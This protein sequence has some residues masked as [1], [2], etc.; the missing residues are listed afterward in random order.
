MAMHATVSR[1]PSGALPDSGPPL[2]VVSAAE[3]IAPAELYMR[4]VTAPFE[5]AA[6]KPML[7]LIRTQLLS[8][9]DQVAVVAAAWTASVLEIGFEI[10]RY[11]GPLAAN[12]PWVALVGVE[13]GKL[14]PGPYEVAVQTTVLGFRELRHPE[15]ATKPTV[16]AQRFRFTCV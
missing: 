11:T 15:N 5:C 13:L 16:S 6:G 7:A 9:P 12:D 4:H 2:I 10:R 3:G 14:D 1:V 8:T